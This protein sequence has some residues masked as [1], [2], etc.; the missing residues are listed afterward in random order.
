MTIAISTQIL[1]GNLGDGWNDQNAAAD[2][3][4][5]YTRQTWTRD[6]LNLGYSKNEFEID[7]DVQ[8]G[9]EGSPKT[10]TVDADNPETALAL[11]REL[12]FEGQ[13]WEQFCGTEMA[14]NL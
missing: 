13:I 9:W 12:T 4:A 10:M 6:M 14:A 1:A 3:L 7:I 5:E 8:H 2:A 11:E